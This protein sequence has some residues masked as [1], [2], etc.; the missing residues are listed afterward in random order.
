M[1]RQE[2]LTRISIVNAEYFAYHGVR[3]AEKSLGGRFQVDVDIFYNATSAV[4]SDN[5]NDTVNYEEVLFFVNEVVCYDIATGLLDRFEA[6]R[7]VTA[8]VRKLNVPIQQLMDYVES[9][10]T[11]VREHA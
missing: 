2:S 9:E 10:F 1:A 3:P 8:R 7:Q 11:A 4:V 5:I 6:A